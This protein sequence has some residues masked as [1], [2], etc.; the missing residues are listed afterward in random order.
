MDH[1]T[2]IREHEAVSR[3]YGDTSRDQDDPIVKNKVEARQGTN[4]APMQYVLLGGLVLVTISFVLMF[5]VH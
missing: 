5:L 1:D 2:R 4:R 3:D